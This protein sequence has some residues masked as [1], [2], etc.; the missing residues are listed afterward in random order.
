MKKLYLLPPSEGKKTGWLQWKA[1]LTFSFSLPLDIAKNATEKDLKCT[2]KR[3]EEW[4]SL[5][6]S[7][8]K[9]QV[10]PAIERYTWVMFKAIDYD[11]FSESQ[12]RDFD[13]SVLIVSWLY[14][15][16]RPDDQ[17][18]NYK[19]PIGAKW[20]KEYRK[21]LLTDGLVDYCHERWV[22]H[23]V[24]L[25]P[26]IHQKVFDR[27]KIESIWLVREQKEFFQTLPDGSKK[28]LTHGVK[29]VK[30]EWLRE[31]FL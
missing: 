18:E 4:F 24:D 27:E 11:S 1:K 23:L 10:L 25:L 3:Y 29:K 22:T 15:L 19:L 7:L 14:G 8:W 17:I 31:Q 26:Q 13:D 30:G 9:N 20:L 21:P 6:N 5:N 12:Q 2:G 16:L 28:K